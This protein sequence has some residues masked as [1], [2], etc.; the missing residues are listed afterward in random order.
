MIVEYNVYAIVQPHREHGHRNTT[1]LFVFKSCNSAY[2]ILNEHLPTL[3]SYTSRKCTKP[4]KI[5]CMVNSVI[6]LMFMVVQVYY[7]LYSYNHSAYIC[8][9]HDVTGFLT[10]LPTFIEKCIHHHT[11]HINMDTKYYTYKDLAILTHIVKKAPILQN[12]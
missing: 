2:I 3:H 8:T 5:I 9:R 6:N 4:S 1:Q 7:G 11:W 12:I 10:I